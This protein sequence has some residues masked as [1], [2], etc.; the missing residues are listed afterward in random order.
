VFLKGNDLGFAFGQPT[1][2]TALKGGG[3]P[4]DGNYAFELYYNFQ[5]TDNIKITPALFYL[6]RPLGQ[7]TRNLVTDGSGYDG[8]FNVFGG[9]IQTTFK[10]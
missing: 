10:F 2:A 8:T 1:F 9:L 7:G 5:V 6:S 4:F 3:T